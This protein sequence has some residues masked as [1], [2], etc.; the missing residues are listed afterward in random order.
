MALQYGVSNWI[1][2]DESLE[3]TFQRLQRYGFD[4]VELVGEPD[5]YAVADVQALCRKYG[6]RVLTICG[7]FPWPTAD[8]D[9]S[10]PD[11]AVRK[12]AVNYLRRLTEFGAALGAQAIV[13]TPC[14]VMKVSPVGAPREEEG[15]RAAAKKEWRWGVESIQAA[16]EYAVKNGIPFAVEPI[17][18]YET[19]LI[20]SADQGLAF[21]GEVGRPG[22]GVHLDSFHM[23]IE[24][25]DP[26][27]AVHRVGG[28]LRNVHIADSNRQ[29]VGYGHFDFAGFV[30]ALVD[31][32]YNG[33]VILEPLPPVPDPY[34][35]ARL[36]SGEHLKDEYARVSIERL[37][38][39]ESAARG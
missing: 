20:N 28:L 18:R 10:S 1:Y 23:N 9:L 12:L 36:K 11:P 39:F 5:R 27:A 4:G 33:P 24:D 19:Y 34:I 16:S 30:K 37:R 17:N 13:C 21:V 31:T 25:A 15:W 14:P 38:A 8:R 6:L 32:G 22:V 3:T 26:V 2:G 29:A 7:M 35:A